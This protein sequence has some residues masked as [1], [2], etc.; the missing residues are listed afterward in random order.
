MKRASSDLER[1]VSDLKS[2]NRT[3]AAEAVSQRAQ[4]DSKL[5]EAER[6]YG[7][8]Q[9]RACGGGGGRGGGGGTGAWKR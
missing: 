5:A 1:V 6:K 2:A 3:A 7:A 8:L 4:F 9:V